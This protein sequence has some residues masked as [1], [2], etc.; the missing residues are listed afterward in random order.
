M[1]VYAPVPAYAD[2]KRH[3]RA[4]LLIVAGHVALLAAVMTAKMDIGGSF[5]PT[6]TDVKLIP[7]PPEPAP[8]PPQP[9]Q[10]P[11]NSAIDTVPRVVPVPQPHFPRVDTRQ[12]PLPDP[13]PVIGPGPS[14]DTRPTPAPVRTGPRFIT[15]DSRLKPPYPQQK[16]RL[17]EE[18][19]L[20]LRLSIDE[21]GRVAAVEPVGRADPVFLAAARRHLIALWRYQPATE[22]GRAIAS[23]TVITLSFQLEN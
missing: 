6:K 4:L 2:R 7:V 16:L 1:T 17:E 15:P 5:I 9:K 8:N 14:I 11:R 23:S 21:R 12:L 22:N 18:A 3:P 20:R 19:V 10:E 13:G